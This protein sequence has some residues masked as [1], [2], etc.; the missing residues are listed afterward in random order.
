MIGPDFA[1]RAAVYMILPI[2][3][4]CAAVGVLLFGAGLLIGSLIW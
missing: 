3:I 1:A 2:L 4:G